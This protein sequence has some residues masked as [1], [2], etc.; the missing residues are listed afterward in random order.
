MYG[1]FVCMHVCVLLAYLVPERPEE[2]VGSSGA[3]V[4]SCHVE[5]G[6]QEKQAVL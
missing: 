2:G 5:A 3:G 6:P 1:F 4:M